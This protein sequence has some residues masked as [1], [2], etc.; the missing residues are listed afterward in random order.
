MIRRFEQ[1]HLK[2]AIFRYILSISLLMQKYDNFIAIKGVV[3][4]F[5]IVILKGAF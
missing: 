4:N 5:H 3:K 1:P 2:K